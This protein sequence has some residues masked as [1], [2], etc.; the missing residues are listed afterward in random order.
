MGPDPKFTNMMS[1]KSD[2]KNRDHG[3]SNAACYNEDIKSTW[4]IQTIY[5][6][7]SRTHLVK[8][9]E[10]RSLAP[11][12]NYNDNTINEE[13]FHRLISASTIKLRRHFNFRRI[14][15]T[16]VRQGKEER[17]AATVV[18][19]TTKVDRQTTLLLPLQLFIRLRQNYQ[20]D[21]TVR[22]IPL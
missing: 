7:G 15:T 19:Q 22:S 18:V 16:T 2:T 4:H 3:I 21:C 14:F 17:R 20:L 5:G 12:K 6:L 1:W 11:S 13:N 10:V 8:L 9:K